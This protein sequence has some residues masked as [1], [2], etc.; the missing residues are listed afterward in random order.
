MGQLVE[1]AAHDAH[2]VGVA[3]VRDEGRLGRLVFHVAAQMGPSET[4]AHAL[5]GAGEKLLQDIVG[6]RHD[7]HHSTARLAHHRMAAELLA[8]A[9]QIVQH[10]GCGRVRLAVVVP[11][12]DALAQSLVIVLEVG[13]K[14]LQR[15]R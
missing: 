5:L 14:R 8:I 9:V 10:E 1:R 11:V 3:Q 13:G 15:M 2:I 4:A 7:R 12:L 6:A